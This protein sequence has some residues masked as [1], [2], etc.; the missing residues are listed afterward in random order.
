MKTGTEETVKF[1]SFWAKVDNMGRNYTQMVNSA[2]RLK[3]SDAYSRSVLEEPHLVLD[4]KELLLQ[5]N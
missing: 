2:A 1:S 3:S 5:D 4:V